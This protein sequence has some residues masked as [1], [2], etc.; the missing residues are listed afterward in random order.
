MHVLFFPADIIFK[1]SFTMRDK[2]KK[3]T[4]MIAAAALCA[5]NGMQYLRYGDFVCGLFG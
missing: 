1:E 2:F 5:V 3:L 4:S